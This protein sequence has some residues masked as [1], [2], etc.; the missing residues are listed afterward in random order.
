MAEW[1][2]IFFDLGV[3][4]GK[5]KRYFNMVG[6]IEEDMWVGKCDKVINW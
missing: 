3:K 2:L 1:I 5:W 6:L 4:T